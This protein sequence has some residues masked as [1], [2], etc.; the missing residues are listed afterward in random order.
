[1][2]TTRFFK[3][4]I[5]TIT[6]VLLIGIFLCDYP[7][8]TI[9][10][11]SENEEYNLVIKPD[12]EVIALMDANDFPNAEKLAR[13]KKLDSRII[14]VITAFAGKKDES[15]SMFLDYLKKSPNNKRE[16]LALQSVKLIDEVSQ[17]LS[18]ELLEH[19]V[20]NNILQKESNRVESIKI[21]WLL[22]QGT[23]SGAEEKITKILNAPDIIND[24]VKHVIVSIIEQLKK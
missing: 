6:L 12:E 11:A 8:T 10:C 3:N 24:D 7:I 21:I 9:I 18:E 16:D 4:H 20:T 17:E 22:R 23:I 13:E 19:L 1:M 5:R 2:I 15:F 14:A